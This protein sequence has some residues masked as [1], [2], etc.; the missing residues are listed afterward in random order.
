MFCQSIANQLSHWNSKEKRLRQLIFN[1]FF[2]SGIENR[3]C[4]QVDSKECP[5][6]LYEWPRKKKRRLFLAKTF[7]DIQEL[8]KEFSIHNTGAGSMT[9]K[10]QWK[11]NR[12]TFSVAINT[13]GVKLYKTIN[14][15]YCCVKENSWASL[16]TD[17]RNTY[18]FHGTCRTGSTIFG[19]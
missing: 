16:N 19:V 11:T 14:T 9:M 15:T 4:S 6:K 3:K 2:V 5:C 1:F 12:I 10:K 13:R 17:I 18:Q 8:Q 7:P